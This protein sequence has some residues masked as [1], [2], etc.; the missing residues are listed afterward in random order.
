MWNVL[1]KVTVRR[2]FVEKCRLGC[3]FG[4]RFSSSHSC[5]Y[6]WSGV[7]HFVI[8]N[9]SRYSTRRRNWSFH[10]IHERHLLSSFVH[11]V[12]L[13]ETQYKIVPSGPSPGL[14]SKTFIFSII[15]P[16]VPIEKRFSTDLD[17][18]IQLHFVPAVSWK[19]Y[20]HTLGTS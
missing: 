7:P 4:F 20:Q 13:Q 1:I 12:P 3:Q 17:Y 2:L 15:R 5:E 16:Y 10:S 14:H 18:V 19:I 8:F 9:K 6:G 11:G